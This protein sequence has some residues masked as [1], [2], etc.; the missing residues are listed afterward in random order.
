MQDEFDLGKA[1]KEDVKIDAGP[2]KAGP[3]RDNVQTTAGPVEIRAVPLVASQ[4]KALVEAQKNR[5]MEYDHQA[6]QLLQ[7][8]IATSVVDS[9]SNDKAVKIGALAS[10]TIKDIDA[11]VKDI[12]GPANQFVKDIRNFGKTLTTKLELAKSEIGKKTANW[13]ALVEM[14][15]RKAEKLALDAATRVQKD[16]NDQSAQLGIANPPQIEAPVVKKEPVV[17][18]TEYGSAYTRVYKK[19]RILDPYALDRK[20]LKPDEAKIQED[21]DAG[22][23]INGVEVYEESKTIFRT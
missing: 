10:K 12:T 21:V 15:R 8:A 5:I 11:R 1:L 7:E 3:V 14:E 2:S 20:Y 13:R 9:A 16:I 4:S 18:R 19:F 22:I 23:P 6:E 17:T